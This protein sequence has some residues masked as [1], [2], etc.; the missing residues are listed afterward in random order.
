MASPFGLMFFFWVM[1]VTFWDDMGQVQCALLDNEARRIEA[2]GS[3]PAP[4]SEERIDAP[5]PGA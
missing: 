3:P 2:L 4:P 5:G 1:A